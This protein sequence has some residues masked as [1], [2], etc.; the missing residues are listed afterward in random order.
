MATLV[1]NNLEMA[2]TILSDA[3]PGE[4]NRVQL[5][6]VKWFLSKLIVKLQGSPWELPNVFL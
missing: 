1:N 5:Q 6:S 4:T 2:L 3:A